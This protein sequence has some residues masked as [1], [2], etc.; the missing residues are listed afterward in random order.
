MKFKSTSMSYTTTDPVTLE[1]LKKAQE[2]QL[3]SQS[4]KHLFRSHKSKKDSLPEQSNNSLQRRKYSLSTPTELEG[5]A[6]E[7]TSKSSDTLQKGQKMKEKKKFSLR[8]LIGKFD[9]SSK[10]SV[11]GKLNKSQSDEL[12]HRQSEQMQAE[13]D[14]VH[15]LMHSPEEMGLDNECSKDH[16]TEC[17]IQTIYEPCSLSRTAIN[18]DRLLRRIDTTNARVTTLINLSATAVLASDKSAINFLVN[19]LKRMRRKQGL[20]INEADDIMPTFLKNPLLLLR[21]RKKKHKSENGI[22]GGEEKLATF[23]LSYPEDDDDG[24]N[25]DGEGDESDKDEI[26]DDTEILW[27]MS[28]VQISTDC[29]TS[30]SDDEGPTPEYVL[31]LSKQIRKTEGVR[32]KQNLRLIRHKK[33]S[34]AALNSGVVP[35]GKKTSINVPP[36]LN[37]LAHNRN[38]MLRAHATVPSG[39]CQQGRKVS[40]SSMMSSS[41]LPHCDGST[42]STPTLPFN[43][44]SLTGQLSWLI[45]E[46]IERGSSTYKWAT[47]LINSIGKMSVTRSTW[48]NVHQQLRETTELLY[49]HR[50]QLI[51]KNYALSETPQGEIAWNKLQTVHQGILYG[52]LNSSTI[53]TDRLRTLC[54]SLKV[55]NNNNNNNSNNIPAT[56]DPTT[57]GNTE[58]KLVQLSCLLEKK[59]HLAYLCDLLLWKAHKLIL[60]DHGNNDED[61]AKCQLMDFQI[62]LLELQLDQANGQNW[63]PELMDYIVCWMSDICEWKAEFQP[64]TSD[65]DYF[66]WNELYVFKNSV[67]N[68]LDLVKTLTSCKLIRSALDENGKNMIDHKQS[69]ASSSGSSALNSNTSLTDLSSRSQSCRSHHY[70]PH[71]HHHGQGDFRTLDADRCSRSYAAMIR[72]I[73]EHAMKNR[74]LGYFAERALYDIAVELGCQVNWDERFHSLSKELLNAWKEWELI[75]QEKVDRDF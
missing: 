5:I 26:L 6:D 7:E 52:D 56:N 19:S 24:D 34:T 8:K 28:S 18:F 67:Q 21:S 29:S 66:I 15:K 70:H 14:L 43:L 22:N 36:P 50:D 54:K 30:D 3:D 20:A 68:L 1:T 23:T 60:S 12:L 55:N 49:S 38:D 45:S 27:E 2:M 44:L 46:Y 69:I 37:P 35:G 61:V 71:H 47:E 16:E 25:V 10:S 33:S 65:V 31:N 58:R 9:D 17:Y 62:R 48:L 51:K 41:G 53:T 13:L 57:N 73:Q 11:N 39:L 40:S 75:I 4:K 63:S 59:L 72:Q 42:K 64:N 74:P 32:L